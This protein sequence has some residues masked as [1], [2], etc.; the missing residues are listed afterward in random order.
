MLMQ[1]RQMRHLFPLNLVSEGD[2]VRIVAVHGKKE[3]I[4]RLA[5]MGL[6]EE[7]EIQ[8]LKQGQMGITVL[9]G[10]TRWALDIETA[11]KILVVP[12]VSDHCYCC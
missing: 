8:M 5:A 1:T 6:A 9:C 2:E 4:H 12:A 3:L 7:V 11:Q 10:E